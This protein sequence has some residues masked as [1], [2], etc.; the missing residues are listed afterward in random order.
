MS[1]TSG[2]S[3]SHFNE[4]LRYER[5]MDK[6]RALA[7]W[8]IERDQQSE[9]SGS[10]CPEDVPAPG[11]SKQDLFNIIKH[12]SREF[13]VDIEKNSRITDQKI[14]HFRS[15]I[16]TLNARLGI[17]QNAIDLAHETQLYKNSG[18]WE[19][20]W[21]LGQFPDMGSQVLE[22]GI[23]QIVCAGISACVVGEYLGLMIEEKRTRVIPVDHMIFHRENLV[24]V[25]GVLPQNFQFHG[26]R[27]LLVEDAVEESR[28]LWAMMQTLG[29]TREDLN[30]SLLALDIED[31][32]ET[33]KSLERISKVYRFEE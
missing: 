26:N 23:A 7:L 19:M 4:M 17:T 24:P 10:T 13:A 6:L 31:N 8:I 5:E 15:A 1:L 27:I 11:E 3:L 21:Y 12:F 18:F 33:R 14:D 29:D 20:R 2:I 9:H 32:P 22:D 30:F 16:F 28:T 25:Q